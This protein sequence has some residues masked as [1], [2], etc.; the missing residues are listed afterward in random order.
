MKLSNETGI[1]FPRLKKVA[2][3]LI[4]NEIE[5]YRQGRSKYQSY[6]SIKNPGKY[7]LEDSR[8]IYHYKSYTIYEGEL[9]VRDHAVPNSL[10]NRRTIKRYFPSKTEV[11]NH[12]DYK[13]ENDE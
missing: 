13:K 8:L 5:L 7:T 3:E 9:I 11:Q 2:E 1:K 12:P 6:L 10:I 4:V